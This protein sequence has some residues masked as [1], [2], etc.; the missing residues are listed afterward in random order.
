MHIFT[1]GAETHILDGYATDCTVFEVDEAG[2]NIFYYYDSPTAEEMQAFESS[3]PGEI[4]MARIDGVLFMFCKLGTFRW[5]EMPYAIQLSKLTN[6]PHPEE[7]QGYNL[8]IVLIDRG[9]SIIKKIRTVGLDTKFSEAFKTEVSKDMADVLF[10]P[11]Y[12]M[13]VREI[14]EAYPTWALVAKSRVGYEFGAQ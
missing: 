3:V 8:T 1:I 11:T 2:L 12:R 4:R 6:L 7:G 13:R 5:V 9:T 10:E 14:Q